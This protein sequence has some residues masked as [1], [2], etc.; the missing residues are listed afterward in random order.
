MIGEA[1]SKRVK[2]ITL[3]ES[4][5]TSIKGY[6]R[7]RLPAAPPTITGRSGS[8]QGANIVKTPARKEVESN[9]KSNIIIH[10]KIVRNEPII[11]S[12]LLQQEVDSVTLAT[13]YNI[14]IK[15]C[16]SSIW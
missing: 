2:R 1:L 5:V 4:E 9:S 14:K 6:Q 3:V 12:N 16:G 8:T 15:S 13:S 11:A 10:Y 7:F